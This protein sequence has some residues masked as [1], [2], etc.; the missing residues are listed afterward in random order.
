MFFFPFFGVDE[1]MRFW[2]WIL[3]TEVKVFAY[4]A[5]IGWRS[6][7]C[8][9]VWSELENHTGSQRAQNSLCGVAQVYTQTHIYK[10]LLSP[11]LPSSWP[12]KAEYSR[13]QCPVSQARREW[14]LM[15]PSRLQKRR[16]DNLSIHNTVTLKMSECHCIGLEKIKTI[17]FI[18]KKD[19]IS[20]LCK[21]NIPQK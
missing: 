9:Y 12:R 14:T 8:V 15:Q 10:W 13:G 5:N 3:I 4:F 19:G 17:S 2:K 7:R 1:G 16:N 20:T 6:L 11:W 18:L 21:H